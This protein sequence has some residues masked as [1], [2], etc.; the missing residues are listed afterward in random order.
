MK[1]K[2]IIAI[3]A[4]MSPILAL[5][6]FAEPSGFLRPL[7]PIAEFQRTE[8]IWASAIIAIAILPVL[9]GAPLI[10]WRYRRSNKN[11]TYRPDWHFDT[12]LEV[13][14]WGVPTL[15]VIALSVWLT[16]AVYRIDPYR[17]ID[18]E[19]A[20]GLDIGE[21]GAPIRI[22]TVGLDWKWLFLYPEE[23][24]ASVGEMVIPTGRPVAMRLT[25]DTVMQ[26][27]M[28][29]GLAGQIYAMAG[30]VTQLNLIA[31]RTGTTLAENT[32]YNGTGFPAQRAPVEAV[33]PTAYGAWLE[34]ARAAP[35]L[36][37]QS[38]AIL[39][40]S[41][42][43]AKARADLGRD[44]DGPLLFRL[45]D[46]ALF[47]RIVGRYRSGTPVPAAAQPGSPSYD[48]GQ[49][50]P[51]TLAEIFPDAFCGPGAT[52]LAQVDLPEP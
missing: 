31:T 28:A 37:A 27:F 34:A 16:Q 15:I 18:A 29:S 22:E 20:D 49:G 25:T 2:I 14:M 52:R 19:M 7:G 44:G 30:M 4:A 33:D 48:P 50:I 12:K 38:Y 40:Q 6:A 13:L 42:D 9:I 8:L 24:I 35:T 23:G 47:D 43:V 3:G 45:D 17:T 10:V 11:A 26:S 5:P 32:Q 39:A 1:R 21:I 51:P 36:N 41:G 46:P